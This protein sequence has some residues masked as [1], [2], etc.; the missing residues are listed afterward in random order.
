MRKIYAIALLMAMAGG[1]S[2]C[3]VYD[4]GD[5][6]VEVASTAVSATADTVCD[7]ACLISSDDKTP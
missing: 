3:A 6:V 2:G 7:I 5:A 1:L 4:A